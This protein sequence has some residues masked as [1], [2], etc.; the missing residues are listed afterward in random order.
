MKKNVSLYIHI[1]FCIK[2][3]LYCDFPSF[4]GMNAYFEDYVNALCSEISEA[5]SEFTD[6]KIKTIFIGGG[7]PTIL[8]PRFLGK[9]MDTV[10]TKYDV[11]DAEISIE[12]NPGT[13]D[14]LKLNELMQMYFNRLS[15]GLQS[16]Q[17][18]HLKALGR[19]HTADDFK[20]NYIEAREAGFKNINIDLMFSLPN[21]TIGD[22][23]ETLQNVIFLGP[24]HISA[25]SLIIEEGTPFYEMAQKGVIHEADDTLDRNM[26]Y[27]ANRILAQNGYSRYEI[28]NFAKKGYECEH[29]KVYW[30]TEE[31]RGFGL[32]AHSYIN[33]ERFH[34]V[35]DF[36]GYTE[37][38]G[39]IKKLITDVEK[40]SVIEKQEE[41]MFMGLR[42]T[43]GISESDFRDRFSH[44]IYDVYGDELKELIKE[45]LIV[46]QND[47]LF[48]SERG[49]D[50]SNQVFEKF[51]RS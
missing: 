9:I 50:V 3:C 1:P 41:F 35:Y 22:W 38:K 29:N 21:Q 19:I 31:Y 12:S 44:N 34:N 47:R 43:K 24:E 49:I 28:S 8:Q 32:G 30:K 14:K 5:S 7:T 33:G 4:G 48:L 46:S 16:W 18:K 13:L 11:D 27:T 45:E 25:Y 23:E 20:R 6:R 10:F 15:M 2:K 40:L 17:D 37:S 36:K 42:M 39:N 51:I 26:Y